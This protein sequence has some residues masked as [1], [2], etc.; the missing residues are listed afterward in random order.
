MTMDS[1]YAMK[2]TGGTTTQVR[3]LHSRAKFNAKLA[4]NT[5]VFAPQSPAASFSASST[6]VSQT[7][8]VHRRQNPGHATNA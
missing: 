4:W 6:Q 5:Q 8:S 2:D 1:A 3:A 7:P